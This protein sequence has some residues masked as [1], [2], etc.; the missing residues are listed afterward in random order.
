M[1]SSK[2]IPV[3]TYLEKTDAPLFVQRI[4]CRELLRNDG[5]F[6]SL[7]TGPSTTASQMAEVTGKVETYFDKMLPSLI[8]R[9]ADGI[10]SYSNDT[11]KAYPYTSALSGV[12]FGASSVMQL[13]A[14][15]KL[16]ETPEFAEFFAEAKEVDMGKAVAR[17]DALQL[18]VRT[19]IRRWRLTGQSAEEVVKSLCDRNKLFTNEN[20][21]LREIHEEDR[22][23]EILEA[24]ESIARDPE[25]KISRFLAPDS[26]L[27]RDPEFLLIAEF[28]R[29]ELEGK[30]E[31]EVRDD[32]LDQAKLFDDETSPLY[33]TPKEKQLRIM[34]G[35]KA[36]VDQQE[37]DLLKTLQP[38]SIATAV[39]TVLAGQGGRIAWAIG[40]FGKKLKDQGKEFSDALKG[41]QDAIKEAQKN[42]Q[43][44]STTAELLKG[45]LWGSSNPR[46]ERLEKLPDRYRKLQSLENELRTLEAHGSEDSVRHKKKEIEWQ[47]A[48]IQVMEFRR[49]DVIKYSAVAAGVFE[50]G[51]FA[52]NFVAASIDD[53]Q[54]AK[55][56]K[57]VGQALSTLGVVAA[58]AANLASGNVLGALTGLMG[59]ANI[60]GP[61][62]EAQRHKQIMGALDGLSEGQRD[63]MKGVETLWKGQR[64][65]ALGQQRLALGQ[66]RLALGQKSLAEGQQILAEGISKL[67]VQVQESHL[68]T[69]KTLQAIYGQVVANSLA[70]QELAGKEF[71]AGHSFLNARTA[72]KW[73]EGWQNSSFVNYPIHRNFF[74]EWHEQFGLCWLHLGTVLDGHEVSQ[75]F[76]WDPNLSAQQ[77]GVEFKDKVYDRAR[78]ILANLKVDEPDLLL[79]ALAHPSADI[80]SSLDERLK[81]VRGF[82][83]IPLFEESL[84][85]LKKSGLDTLVSPH[86]LEQYGSVLLELHTY[87]PLIR[88]GN[89]NLVEVDELQNARTGNLNTMGQTLLSRL[90]WLID[91]GIAQQSLIAGELILPA[92][93]QACL[94][95]EVE[96]G[97]LKIPEHV[98]EVMKSN[99]LLRKN[100]SVYVVQRELPTNNH[101]TLAYGYTLGLAQGM[102]AVLGSWPLCVGG[103]TKWQLKMSE[104]LLIDL[105]SQS[106][107]ENGRMSYSPLMGQLASLRRAVTQAIFD[108]DFPVWA[109]ENLSEPERDLVRQ[110]LAHSASAEIRD[111]A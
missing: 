14:M 92:L 7:A 72:S 84:I 44:E 59:I 57:T 83:T 37:Q 13:A 30:S 93:Y 74:S 97:V 61:N 29:R 73:K 8:V 108:Y 58:S 11:D 26:M 18:I 31:Q 6:P 105:P 109:K 23:N 70:L 82:G 3:L 90:L 86:A 68:E 43:S 15:K 28:Q 103:E 17:F 33:G 91:L 99:K 110:C 41:F 12:L 87:T 111:V 53:P 20:S 9:H 54:A 102:K 100:F 2:G 16:S 78:S 64:E 50:L 79:R 38:F 51:A 46:V 107:V 49:E 52:A 4:V 67:A 60:W 5:T 48:D 19:E 47:K 98:V 65:L 69:M 71:H 35:I 76:K 85:F 34:K 56:A 80:A 94:K 62:I 27:A 55:T 63:I 32:L 101:N 88:E 42:G 89:K 40:K 95:E 75:V 22:Q 106:E 39:N 25:E 36:C 10:P 77:P 66:K 81:Q 45:Q 21:L 104:G 1:E 24:L 96:K